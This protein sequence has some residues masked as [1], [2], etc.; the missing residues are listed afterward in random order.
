MIAIYDFKLKLG[1]ID[2]NANTGYVFRN[3]GGFDN[4]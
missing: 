3:A 4:L 2:K 1:I